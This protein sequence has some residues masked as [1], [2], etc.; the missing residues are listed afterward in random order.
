MEAWEQVDTHIYS[1]GRA[2][3]GGARTNTQN[4]AEATMTVVTLNVR[5]LND[6]K[7]EL[8]LQYFLAEEWDILFLTD[9]FWKNGVT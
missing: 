3:T 4:S 5:G 8:D 6:T 7:L 9:V 1:K 2:S